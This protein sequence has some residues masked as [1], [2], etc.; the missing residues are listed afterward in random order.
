[1]IKAGKYI[2]GYYKRFALYYLIGIAALIAVDFIQIKLADEIQIAVNAFRDAIT[3]GGGWTDPLKKTITDVTLRV[4]LIGGL[5]F[6]GRILWR[7]TIFFASHKIESLIRRDMFMKAER[8]SVTFY[9]DNKV[10]TVMAWFTTDLETIE[11]YMGWGTIMLIDAIF[12]TIFASVKMFTAQWQ[13]SIVVYIPL[14]LIVIWGFLVE[15]FSSLRWENR[16][17]A[18]DDL[19]DF[20]QES[21]TGIRVIKAFVKENQQ[22]FAFK[23]V[24]KKSREANFKMGHLYALFDALI[25]IIIASISV[26]ILWLGGWVI[27]NHVNGNT[28]SLFGQPVVM[29]TGQ[30]SSFFY[31]F[32][33]LIWPLIALGQIISLH[34]RYRTSLKR[35][36]HYLNAEEDIKDKEGAVK[37]ENVKGKITFKNFSFIYPDAED[38]VT[39]YIRNIS[40]TI[41]AGEKIGIVG[42]IGCGKTTLVNILLRLYNVHPG[43]V[44][45][46]DVDIMDAQ[47]TSLRDNI[48]Y[49]P[50]DNFLFGDTINNNISFFNRNADSEQVKAAAKFAGVDHD[51]DEFKDNYQTVTGERGVTLSGGQKQRI[52]I[53]RAYIKKAPILILDDSVSAVDV[54]TEETI[55]HNIQEERKEQTTIVV[56]S[57]VSTVNKLDRI[58]VMNNGEI[59]AFAPHKELMEIS[60][61]YK[62]MVTLQEL[63]KEIEEGGKSSSW[64]TQT[65]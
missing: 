41:N 15:K 31:L 65:K 25:E 42:K 50:Q 22:F 62:K 27:Y 49:V 54:K 37:L 63:E 18:Y 10:G 61:T 4:L 1:M 45:I 35:V 7:I 51:I 21:F 20:S 48:A 17:K 47:I 3:L 5:M 43:T 13:L 34:S 55:L 24:A 30:L 26:I 16:Q 9:H 57:R 14:L 53:A 40:F 33:A 44:F 64:Q 38:Q 56:A 60:P 36:V 12:L 11:E 58:L 32:D 19:Y 39:P 8:L 52:S 2:R 59:E 23:K 6:L 46:D 28:I 29:D